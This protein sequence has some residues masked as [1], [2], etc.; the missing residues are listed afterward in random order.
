MWHG[1]GLPRVSDKERTD[2]SKNDSF[3]WHATSSI[4]GILHTSSHAAAR[5]ENS[6]DNQIKLLTFLYFVQHFTCFNTSSSD[7]IFIHSL[8][9]QFITSTTSS[10]FCSLRR[11]N[12][13]RYIRY[14]PLVLFKG[15][16]KNLEVLR[17]WY[18]GMFSKCAA[19][20]KSFTN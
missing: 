11:Y 15:L 14:I 2:R 1:F 13:P 4:A 3:V 6:K 16:N 7:C 17:P 20:P 10:A 9:L 18:A 5:N 12:L 19:S 8:L